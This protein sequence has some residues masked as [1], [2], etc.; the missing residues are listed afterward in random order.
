[1]EEEGWQGASDPSSDANTPD[2][3]QRGTCPYLHLH[4]LLLIILKKILHCKNVMTSQCEKSIIQERF[5]ECEAVGRG[6]GSR[7]L[8][9]PV[10]HPSANS[11]PALDVER[12][13]GKIL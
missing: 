5:S 3:A 10:C 2:M 11:T 6:V 9:R 8:D 12:F 4:P 7:D 13:C 1:M